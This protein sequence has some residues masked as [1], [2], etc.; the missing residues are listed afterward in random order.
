MQGLRPIGK[1]SLHQATLHLRFHHLGVD[2]F[3][4]IESRGG[5]F[6]SSVG[7][8]SVRSGTRLHERVAIFV[9]VDPNLRF[10]KLGKPI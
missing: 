4:H 9:F 6:A 10:L 2:G 8:S 1:H 3:A 5:A 7:S